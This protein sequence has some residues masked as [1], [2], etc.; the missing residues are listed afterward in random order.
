MPARSF[1]L[2]QVTVVIAGAPMM[3]QS[4]SVA[5]ATDVV[6]RVFRHLRLAAGLTSLRLSTVMD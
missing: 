3:A 1:L 2:L 5:D 6:S 4:Q